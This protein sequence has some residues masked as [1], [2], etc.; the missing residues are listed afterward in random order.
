[1]TD[2]RQNDGQERDDE[3]LTIPEVGREIRAIL[4]PV[5]GS[6][7]SEKGLAYASLLA[8][9]TGASIVVV[10]AF[11]PPVAIRRRGI[12]QVEYARGEMEEEATELAAEAV[13]LLTE[14]GHSAR[15]VVVRGDPVM[16]ILE[17]AED[18]HADLIVMGRRG[19][20]PL[21]GILMGSVSEKVARHAEIPVVLAH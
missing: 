10:V 20:G 16:A 5:D 17:T 13:K 15:S 14:R 11:D 7:G 2:E 4:C 21:A 9:L 6:E 3:A 12:L 1:M 18:E 19:L 8:R